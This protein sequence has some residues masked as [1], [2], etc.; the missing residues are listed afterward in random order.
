MT[1]LHLCGRD[2]APRLLAL[3]AQ[4]DAEAGRKRDAGAA[5]GAVLDGS[6][7]GACY[8][9]GP[10]VSPVGYA[11]LSFGW[12]PLHG[13]LLGRIEEIW[14]RPGVRGRGMAAEVMQA[15]AVALAPHGVRALAVEA[16]PDRAALFQRAG[17]RAEFRAGQA[18]TVML[19]RL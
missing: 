17:F 6:P 18:A 16:A 3:V 9:L 14:I 5:F 2:D 13:G 7:H 10:S 11:A 1:A 8:L 12:S 15:L 19:R 4:A